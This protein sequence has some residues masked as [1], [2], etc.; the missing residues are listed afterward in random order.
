MEVTF[1]IFPFFGVSPRCLS[2]LPLYEHK[3]QKCVSQVHSHS[4]GANAGK[5]QIVWRPAACD[6]NK[7]N[8]KVKIA[9]YGKE[10][11]NFLSYTMFH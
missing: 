1:K 11:G 3:W 10:I 5:E 4:S 6:S 2:V 9:F 7:G 8:I